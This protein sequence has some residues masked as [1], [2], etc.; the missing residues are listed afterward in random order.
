MTSP[1]RTLEK[2]LRGT[3]DANIRFDDLRGLLAVLGFEERIKG[4]HHIF[5]LQGKEAALNLQPHGS[6][7]KTY[8]VKQARRIII[9]Q[10]LATDEE[11]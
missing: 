4:S 6:K 1:K 11:D 3:S 9:D 7:A 5:T 10:R 2:V 8:Q